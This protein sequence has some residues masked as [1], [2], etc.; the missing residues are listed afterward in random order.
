MI[1][2]IWRWLVHTG[3][4]DYGL[5]YGHWGWYSFWS[6][7]AGSFLV[8]VTVWFFGWY[9]HHTCHTWW[10]PRHAKYDFTDEATGITY[11]LCRHCHPAHTGE[12]L[13]RRRIAHI[14]RHNKDQAGGSHEVVLAMRP[15]GGTEHGQ[16]LVPDLPEGMAP[17]QEGSRAV[18]INPEFKAFRAGHVP[19]EQ[20]GYLPL[21]AAGAVASGSKV[22]L[23]DC[24][25]FQASITDAA[26]LNWSKA[27]VIRSLYGTSHVDTA[28][29]SGARRLALHQGGVRFCGIYQFLVAGQDGAAQARAFRT[30]VGA[31]QPGEVF[32]ADCEQ[33]AKAMLTAWYNEMVKLYGNGI[34]PYLWTYTGLSFGQETGLLPVQWIA[35]YQSA[36]P[37]TPHTLWQFTDSYAVPGVGTCDASLYHGSIDELAALAYGGQQ[38]APKPT[39]GPVQ[40]PMEE[41]MPAG[42]VSAA[43]GTWEAFSWAGGQVSNIVIVCGGWQEMQAVPPKFHLLINH[44]GGQPYLTPEIA[45]PANGTWTYEIAAP[46]DCN[47]FSIWR[48][49]GG[50]QDGKAPLSYHTL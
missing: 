41:D 23:A 48:V 32:I 11:R 15:V 12:R 5:P 35:A 40:P 8:G 25:E 38:P 4:I 7:I 10:C 33:G 9:I 21:H 16:R 44:E 39:P 1:A 26:Y 18:S 43:K 27:I 49:D 3:G 2:V 29:Y 28:W 46:A 45:L 20:P 13:T 42:P 36:E 22:L 19:G 31:I 14:H 17:R 37:S 30:L 6:G 50:D 47:G 24:S 34:K